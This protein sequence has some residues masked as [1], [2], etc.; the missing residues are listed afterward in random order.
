MSQ[1]PYLLNSN[2]FAVP[3]TDFDISDFFF[4]A[5]YSDCLFFI[6]LQHKEIFAKFTSTVISFLPPKSRY[7]LISQQRPP[8]MPSWSPRSVPFTQSLE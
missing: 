5:C 1:L 8:N 2:I 3:E 7:Y 6:W 4:V